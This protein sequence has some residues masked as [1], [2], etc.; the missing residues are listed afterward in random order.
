MWH[1]ALHNPFYLPMPGRDLGPA[2]GVVRKVAVAC[3]CANK[4]CCLGGG[5]LQD[6]RKGAGRKKDTGEVWTLSG[7]Q[8]WGCNIHP[9][10]KPL[11]HPRT[12]GHG[13]VRAALMI[14]PCSAPPCGPEQDRRGTK[15]IQ[16]PALEG[17]GSWARCTMHLQITP[18]PAGHCAQ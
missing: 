3:K 16:T 12:R 8:P 2:G 10:K 18:L 15:D 1:P 11:L 4:W 7:Y 6:G 13:R 9:R 5:D 17:K 14:I